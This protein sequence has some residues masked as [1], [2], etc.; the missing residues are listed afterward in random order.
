MKNNC[1]KF[2]F[3]YNSF[4]L[5]N[6]KGINV[7]HFFTD[8]KKALILEVNTFILCFAAIKKEFKND[9]IFGFNSKYYLFSKILPHHNQ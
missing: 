8:K 2:C 1:I 4:E 7:Y 3:N 5:F 9:S 6:T